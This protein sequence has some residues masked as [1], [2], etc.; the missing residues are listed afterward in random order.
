MEKLFW[1]IGEAAKLLDEN[2]SA[3]RFWTNSFP[4]YIRPERTV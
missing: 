3:V 4:E 1:T 2:V